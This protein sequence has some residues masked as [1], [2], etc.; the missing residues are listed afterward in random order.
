MISS[1]AIKEMEDREEKRA[2]MS[3]S[4]TQAEKD[5]AYE[6]YSSKVAKKSIKVDKRKY[7]D[8]LATETE[9]AAH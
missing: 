9:E 4:H 3:N 8:M 7:M 2:E 6:R 1:E 5:L